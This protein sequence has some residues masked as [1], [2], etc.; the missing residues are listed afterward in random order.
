MMM[1]LLAEEGPPTPGEGG[2]CG[3]LLCVF[4]HHV[5]MI[6]RAALC[7]CWESSGWSCLK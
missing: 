6:N 4:G 5:E 7:H 1:Y 2:L 3:Y